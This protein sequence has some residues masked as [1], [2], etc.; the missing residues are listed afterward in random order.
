[1]KSKNRSSFFLVCY[2]AAAPPQIV[3]GAKLDRGLN[4]LNKS[5]S[6]VED[7]AEEQTEQM[8]R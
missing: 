2:P 5:W 7:E 1:M 8:A 6:L 4:L 3:A